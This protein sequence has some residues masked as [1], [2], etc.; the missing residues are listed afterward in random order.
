MLEE[1]NLGS[2]GNSVTGNLIKA[3]PPG[4]SNYLEKLLCIN[5][6]EFIQLNF[7]T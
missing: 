2:I 7:T 6:Q 4:F 3:F 1:L 5:Y